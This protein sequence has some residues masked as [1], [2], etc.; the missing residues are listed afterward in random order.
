MEQVLVNGTTQLD[1][2]ATLLSLHCVIGNL[3]HKALA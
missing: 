1:K 3:Q 2:E